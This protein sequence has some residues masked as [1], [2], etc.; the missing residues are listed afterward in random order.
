MIV[1]GPDWCSGKKLY[2]GSTQQRSQQAFMLNIKLSFEMVLDHD[3]TRE[4]QPKTHGG[5]HDLIYQTTSRGG[6]GHIVTT[7]NTSLSANVS[8]AHIQHTNLWVEMC[9]GQEKAILPSTLVPTVRVEDDFFPCRSPHSTT[10]RVVAIFFLYPFFGSHYEAC[11]TADKERRR[12]HQ[13]LSWKE[14]DWTAVSHKQEP[15]EPSVMPSYLP[16]HTQI[17]HLN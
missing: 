17:Y 15:A 4:T 13:K 12:N 2:P 14:R 8:P 9:T 7:L 6:Q 10:L 16:K 11:R 5:L 1:I 3:R